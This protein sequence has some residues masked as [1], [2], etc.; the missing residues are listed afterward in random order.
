MHLILA[1]DW[2]APSHDLDQGYNAIKWRKPAEEREVTTLIIS[3]E[4]DQEIMEV[5]RLTFADNGATNLSVV[6][7]EKGIRLKESWKKISDREKLVFRYSERR[8]ENGEIV[9]E[10]IGREVAPG[11]DNY[12]WAVYSLLQRKFG[13]LIERMS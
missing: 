7:G 2:L 1:G 3:E 5:G 6:P 10:Y 4:L 11:E 9:V 8:M 13:Y 12:K